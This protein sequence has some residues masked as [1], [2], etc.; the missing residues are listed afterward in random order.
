MVA[1][2]QR[3]HGIPPDQIDSQRTR[4]RLAVKSSGWRGIGQIASHRD[5]DRRDVSV[6]EVPMLGKLDVACLH[7]LTERREQEVLVHRDGNAMRLS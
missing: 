2:G 5:E 1:A 7:T 4:Q 6:D 3:P